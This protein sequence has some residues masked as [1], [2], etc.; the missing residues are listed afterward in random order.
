M[1][2]A[3]YKWQQPASYHIRRTEYVARVPVLHKKKKEGA[4]EDDN[5]EE[6]EEAGDE[7]SL[8]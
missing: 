8:V 7:E 4:G 5:D 3:V 2:D 1:F 6:A